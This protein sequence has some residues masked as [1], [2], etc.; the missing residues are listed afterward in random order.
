MTRL[1]RGVE[2]TLFE[3][4]GTSITAGVLVREIDARI[5]LVKARY[6]RE[7]GL[8]PRLQ[9]VYRQFDPAICGVRPN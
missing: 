1:K 5:A 2:L 9:S 3:G 6:A 7:S 8:D 4:R